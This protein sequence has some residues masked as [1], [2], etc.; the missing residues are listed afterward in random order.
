[1]SES[2]P[3]LHWVNEDGRQTARLGQCVFTICKTKRGFKLKGKGIIPPDGGFDIESNGTEEKTKAHAET[4]AVAYVGVT[5]MPL[6]ADEWNGKYPRS[7]RVKVAHSHV[8]KGVVGRTVEHAFENEGVHFIGVQFA[9]NGRT[10]P[11]RLDYI[12]MV[13]G[14]NE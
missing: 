10:A 9:S 5:G 2:K 4:L 7:M 14:P 13:I 8:K 12:M 1:M 11:V 3:I 6:T